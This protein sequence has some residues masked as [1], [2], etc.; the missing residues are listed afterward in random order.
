MSTSEAVLIT[1]GDSGLGK[2]ISL[3]FLKK[4]VD[5]LAISPVLDQIDEMQRIS[6]MSSGNFYHFK[7]D[8][9]IMEDIREVGDKIRLF[10][11]RNN[12]KVAHIIHCAGTTYRSTFEEMDWN[13]YKT[14]LDVNLNGPIFLTQS[15]LSSI[16]KHGSILFIGSVMAEYPHGT[17]LSY[18]IS[19][20]ALKHVTKW[21][22]VNLNKYSIRVN[23]IAPGFINTEWQKA[24]PIEQKERICKKMLIDRFAEPEE[25]CK[26][27]VSI[28]ENEFVDGSIVEINGGYGLKDVS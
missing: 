12:Y 4:G 25:I 1:G 13:R 15:L 28:L 3:H 26:M 11:E 17:S 23:C 22:A 19:K 27:V 21:L 10:L 7:C 20:Y 18:G 16:K 2:Q 24:K 6:S 5:V 9:S 8:L 14:V